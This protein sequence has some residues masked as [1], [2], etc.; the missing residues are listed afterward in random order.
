MQELEIME[1]PGTDYVLENFEY[2][3]NKFIN[4][5][6]LV[7]RNANLN[8]EEQ[9]YFHTKVGEKFGWNLIK[10]ENESSSYYI[11][12]HS[13]NEAINVANKDQIML[14][15]HIEHVHHANPICGAT[16]NMYKFTAD[17]NSGKTYF[18]D[19]SKIYDLLPE[20]WKNFLKKCK[21]QSSLKSMMT[22]SK[23]PQNKQ[24]SEYDV[25]KKHWIT[26]KEIIRINFPN[27]I[28][29]LHKLIK[30]NNDVPTLEQSQKFLEISAYITKQVWEN[31]DLIMFHKWKQGD[32]LIP[33][34]FKLAHA[35]TGGFSPED[36][37]FRGMWGLQY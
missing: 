36:R 15:W 2:Y 20:E 3:K 1:F 7:F 33:D 27:N 21:A 34:M 31:K 35:V 18:I 9:K 25:I 10:G 37:E 30:Y 4:N 29:N 5:S 24:I 16:W 8:Y 11:E 13:H 6:V 19:T 23:D 17:E 28:K 14:S 22:D 32:L 12:N 26:D